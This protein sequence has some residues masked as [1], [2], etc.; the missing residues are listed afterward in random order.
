M[1]PRDIPKSRIRRDDPKEGRFRCRWGMLLT[2][3]HDHWWDVV[4]RR[5]LAEVHGDLLETAQ[6]DLGSDYAT[7]QAQAKIPH[8]VQDAV[9]QIAEYG[10]L[11]FAEVAA[12]Y[13]HELLLR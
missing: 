1:I 2:P 3:A 9:R 11:Y 4:P 10:I 8:L 6:R 5:S 12:S 7:E 13:G